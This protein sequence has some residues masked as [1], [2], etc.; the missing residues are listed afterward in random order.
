MISNEINHIFGLPAYTTKLNPKLYEKNKILSQ[1]EENYK[2][3]KVR[4]KWSTGS[5]IKTDI[6]HSIEDVE[7][8]RFKKI[9]YYSLSKHYEEIITNFF[10][11]LFLTTSLRFTYRIV[12]YSCVR[13][14]SVMTPH[15]HDDCAFSLIHYMSFDNNQHIPT[16]FK[17]PYYFSHL[18]PQKKKLRATF[19]SLKAENSWLWDEWTF[20][21]EEDDVLIVPAILEHC[22]RNLDSKKSRITIIANISIDEKKSK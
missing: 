10:N 20:D 3:S 19:S 18:L 21:T 9:N 6:H 16:I 8:P 22:V 14:N 4:N 17:S 15:I 5:L 13:H 2:L 11:K 7:N 12:N 1:I